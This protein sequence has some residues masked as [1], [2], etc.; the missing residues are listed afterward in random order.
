MLDRISHSFPE[1][2]GDDENDENERD[3]RGDRSSARQ[4]S[5]GKGKG[6]GKEKGKGKGKGKGNERAGG[7]VDS[8]FLV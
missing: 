2:P 8:C 4:A 3:C 7:F 5:K 1:M 6:K